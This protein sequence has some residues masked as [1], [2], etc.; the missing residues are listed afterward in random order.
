MK[1]STGEYAYENGKA[2]RLNGV[3]KNNYL[4]PYNINSYAQLIKGAYRA[5]TPYNTDQPHEKLNYKSPNEFE[6][7]TVKFYRSTKPKME[8]SFTA[9]SQ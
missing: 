6:K 2:E 3:I 1:N 7:E 8:E 4:I 5:V 9:I